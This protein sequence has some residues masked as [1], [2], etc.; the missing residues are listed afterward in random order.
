MVYF[1]SGLSVCFCLWMLK[2]VCHVTVEMRGV[3]GGS[4]RHDTPAQNSLLL[5]GG[6]EESFS[7]SSSLFPPEMCHSLLLS[8]HSFYS[9]RCCLHFL[10]LSSLL[11]TWPLTFSGNPGFSPCALQQY[12]P[13]CT[14]MHWAVSF[15]LT[16]LSLRRAS[17]GC[18]RRSSTPP[19]RDVAPVR[20]LSGTVGEHK[21][22]QHLWSPPDQRSSWGSPRTLVLKRKDT[23]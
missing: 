8:S 5:Q 6:T 13:S 18:M 2:A 7:L 14:I 16:P 1:L 15:F 21:P 17:H 9:C 20:M 19:Q 22:A 23:L 4:C 10:P 12:R 3:N 11:L